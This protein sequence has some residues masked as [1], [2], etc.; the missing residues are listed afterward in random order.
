M[1]E[2]PL[3]GVGG[4]GGA[5]EDSENY[6]IKCPQCGGGYPGFQ[7]LKEHVESSHGAGPLA[8]LQCATTFPTRDLLEKHELLHSPNAQVSCKVCNKTF[9]NVYRLQRHMISHDESANL[10]KFKCPEC[11]KAFKFKHH[12]KEHIRIHSGEKP[13]ECANC[14]KRFSHSG[15]YSSHM[16]S[17]KCLVMNLK[18]NPRGGGRGVGVDISLKQQS[19]VSGA[20]VGGGINNGGSASQLAFRN[21]VPGPP[22]SKRQKI[23]HNNNNNSFSPLYNTKYSEA[24]PAALF[25]NLGL[26]ATTAP[27]LTPFYFPPSLHLNPSQNN[28]YNLNATLNHLLEQLSTTPTQL[29]NNNERIKIKEISDDGET[30]NS[31]CNKNGEV[32]VKQEIK[33]DE[34]ESVKPSITFPERTSP[35]VNS[36]S[37]DLEAV[38][39]ILETV[40][41]TVTKQFLA[42]NMQKLSSGSCSS[43]CPS[44]ASGAPS[45]HV[46][47]NSELYSCRYCRKTFTSGIELNQHERS[48]CCEDVKSEGLAAKLEDAVT[49]KTEIN[50]NIGSG[51][52]DETRGSR[53]LLMT[54]DEDGETIDQDGRKVRVRSQIAEEQL[55][56]LKTHYSL[57]P[58]PK[59]EELSRIAEKVGF[60]VRVVQV[61]FQNN[62]ARD[63]RE[64]RLVHVPYVPLPGCFS[65]V[66][67]HG[68]YSSSDSP[69]ILTEQPLDLSTKKSQTSSPASSP[70]RSD[71]DD[72]G[73]VNLSQKT[74]SSPS[75]LFL[76][77]PFQQRSPSPMDSSSRLAR[78]LTQP[79]L[80]LANGASFPIDR[81]IYSNPELTASRSPLPA[82]ALH[83]NGSSSPG[84]EKQR[85]WKQGFLDGSELTDEAEESGCPSQ[86]PDDLST[87]AKR[88]PKS[89]DLEP[90]GQFTCA[91]CDKA[92]SKQSSLA[93]HK[94]EHSGQ[95]PH[96]CDVCSKAFKHKHHLTEHKRLHSGEKPFQCTKCL[97]RFSHSGSYS[98]HMN[99]RYSYCKPYRE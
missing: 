82:I 97:K 54:E 92:F 47:E 95:R 60:P 63:R 23:I 74:S 24:S 68:S 6:F 20:G 93:R 76:R 11:E 33:E 91:Q 19:P 89:S 38:K 94:Y 64:G 88:P 4:G 37:S 67:L 81:F 77:P 10:R 58:R 73:A 90:E 43:G 30:S 25:P 49:P 34:E 96:K 36:N 35:G 69:P 7:A 9:A 2:V 18:V 98:Q 84:A 87:T 72:C 50:G 52:E 46:E 3:A 5:K 13:F 51:S 12:L 28:P 29:L 57:N 99:H 26:P 8:C 48:L 80:R 55:A 85:S 44:V 65:S 56:V 15:S 75:P 78:I 79:A 31:D 61:W 42:A 86:D 39:R 40:N 62:R 41:A 1:H 59:R 66:P 16:T 83:H 17:K 70:Q 27:A 14:G 22:P 71:S 45:P 21:Q 53:E 32:I